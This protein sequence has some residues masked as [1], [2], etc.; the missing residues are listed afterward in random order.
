[1]SDPVQPVRQH[2]C[3]HDGA[4]LA[5]KHDKRGLE[6]ILRVLVIGEDTA[7]H[8]PNHGSMAVY[9]FGKGHF[10]TVGAGRRSASVGEALGLSCT[11]YYFRCRSMVV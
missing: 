6:C 2:R 7:T 5:K 9:E 3:L 4:G 1:M 8:A 10:V 11:S